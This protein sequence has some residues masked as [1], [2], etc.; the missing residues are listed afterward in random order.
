MRVCR[1]WVDV[2]SSYEIQI[3]QEEKKTPK[4]KW[5]TGK[6][7]RLHKTVAKTMKK[8]DGRILSPFWHAIRGHSPVYRRRRDQTTRRNAIGIKSRKSKRERVCKIHH[9]WKQK[10]PNSCAD[11]LRWSCDVGNFFF[12]D[13][14]FSNK[15]STQSFSVNP[16]F[17]FL[18]FISSSSAYIDSGC[19][20]QFFC[21]H[22]RRAVCL[23]WNSRVETFRERDGELKLEAAE[24]RRATAFCHFRR[25][26]HKSPCAFAD[27]ING[28]SGRWVRCVY[29]YIVSSAQQNDGF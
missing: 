23:V 2:K 7:S 9:F 16:F 19:S 6:S 22:T 4:K 20:F 15:L 28:F 27:S 13:R 29:I 17:L 21:F 8:L 25:E 12:G 18:F 24:R 5:E 3:K 1:P 11:I 14:I 26:G 10:L